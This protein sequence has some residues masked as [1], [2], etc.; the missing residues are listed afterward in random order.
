[1]QTH[2]PAALVLADGTIYRGFA[3][4]ATGKTLGEAVFTTAMTGD[5]QTLSEPS[6]HRLST[7]L[8][9]PHVGNS[10]WNDEGAESRDGNLWS[11]GLFIRD[12]SNTVSNWRSKRSL[13]EGL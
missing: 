8:T 12:L 1:M 11:A 13:N 9:A 5:P 4:G 3:M 2:T 7:V 6:F 10:G